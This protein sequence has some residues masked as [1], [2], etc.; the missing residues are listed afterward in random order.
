MVTNLVWD[1][2]DTALVLEW[3]TFHIVNNTIANIS[4][5]NYLAV[6]G[7]YDVEHRA[8]VHL[9][10]NN[11]SNDDPAMGVTL[12]F[13]PALVTLDADPRYVAKAADDYHLTASS[14]A[15]G[16]GA[17]G[18]APADTLDGLARDASPDI[19]AFEYR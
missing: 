5:H 9:H 15:V 11:F 10:D 7:N 4:T 1:S 12:V 19:G 16:I 14:P 2:G 18:H 3:G 8:S 6:L 17:A 13:Y